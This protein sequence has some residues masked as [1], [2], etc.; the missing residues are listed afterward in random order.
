MFVVVAALKSDLLQ[1]Y[2]TFS[3]LT[4]LRHQGVTVS[5]QLTTNEHVGSLLDSCARTIYGL[6]LL[7]VH[8]VSDDCIQEVFCSTVLAKLVYTNPAWSG[9][10]PAID[11]NKLDQ[12]LNRYKRLNYCNQTTPY[13]TEQ[14]DKA[15]KFLFQTVR[16]DSHHVLHHFLPAIKHHRYQLR[17]WAHS[18][19]LT[20]KSSFHD[21]CNFVTNMLFRDAYWLL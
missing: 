11:V 18:F 12:F 9:F 13:I 20:C 1:P 3:V 4:A 19:T 6:R 8:G 14:F 21:N 2:R 7:W 16:S 17:P 15:D 5:S 10:C